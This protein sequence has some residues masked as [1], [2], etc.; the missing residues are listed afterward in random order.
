[1]PDDPKVQV[2]SFAVEL[3][4]AGDGLVRGLVVPYNQPAT[5]VEVRQDGPIEYRE[6]FARG[7]FERVTRA[8]NAGR[9][10]LLYTHDDILPNHIGRATSFREAD[11]GLYGEFRLDESTADKARDVLTGSHSGLSISFLSIVP[12]AFT[13]RAG[14]L[15][16]RAAAHLRHVAAVSTPAYAMAGVTSVRSGEPEDP[17]SA[18]EVAA[19]AALEEQRRMLAWVEEVAA[20]DRWA[21]VRASL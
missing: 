15:V 1:M 17:P 11:E 14:S 19:A 13:E 2:R 21:A 5:I 16:T 7:A 20:Q 8:G 12:R 18:A 9:V 4:D 3:Q 10:P 6:Q